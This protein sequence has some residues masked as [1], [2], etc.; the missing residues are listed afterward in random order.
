MVMARPGRGLAAGSWAPCPFLPSLLWQ[1]PLPI[2]VSAGA[3]APLPLSRPPQ[4][5]SPLPALAFAPELARGDG[6]LEATQ[7]LLLAL[8]RLGE[9]FVVLFIVSPSA[10]SSQILLLD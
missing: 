2:S 7:L 8:R 10:G 6:S 3:Q 1:I 9:V 5:G 4:E